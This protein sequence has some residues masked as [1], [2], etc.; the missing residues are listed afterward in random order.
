MNS[1]SQVFHS[2]LKIFLADAEYFTRFAAMNRANNTCCLELVHET[3][4]TIVANGEL[5]LYH[6]GRTLLIL[7]HEASNLFEHWVEVLQVDFW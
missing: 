4:S 1:L 2:E 5:A 7:Y 3:A 6:A